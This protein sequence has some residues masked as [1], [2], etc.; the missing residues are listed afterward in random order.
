MTR[1]FREGFMK[2]KDFSWA[3]EDEIDANHQE[4]GKGRKTKSSE[5]QLQGEGTETM[6]GESQ[7]LFQSKKG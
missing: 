6:L 3:S 1:V 2:K 7:T 4:T 5:N